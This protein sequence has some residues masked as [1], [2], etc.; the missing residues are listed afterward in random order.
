MTRI[1]D[2]QT[3]L[4]GTSTVATPALQPTNQ[5]VR[6]AIDDKDGPRLM[7]VIA[8]NRW[9]TIFLGNNT[10][11]FTEDQ[12]EKIKSERISFERITK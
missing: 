6:I 5:R 11:V 7:W 10:F 12:L 2:S 4:G 8:A 1:D 9:P 3:N